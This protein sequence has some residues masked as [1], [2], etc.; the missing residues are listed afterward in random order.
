METLDNRPSLTVLSS[1][2]SPI[3]LL[4]SLTIMLILWDSSW[5][6]IINR[7]LWQFNLKL[8]KVKLGDNIFP[9]SPFLFITGISSQFFFFFFLIRGFRQSLVNNVWESPVITFQPSVGHAT[10]L[11]QISLRFSFNVQTDLLSYKLSIWRKTRKIKLGIKTN[12]RYFFIYNS[13]QLLK[14]K[15]LS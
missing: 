15:H 13:R 5:S 7:C 10:K 9:Q 12:V 8:C 4:Y 11:C 6:I 3:F 14:T 1:I 2:Y